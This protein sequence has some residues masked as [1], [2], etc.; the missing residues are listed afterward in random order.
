MK[1]MGKSIA[2]SLFDMEFQHHP[3]VKIKL[4]SVN[5]VAAHEDWVIEKL[6]RLYSRARVPLD[7]KELD[8]IVSLHAS[9][10]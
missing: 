5:G 7:Q 1:N 8:G 6:K 2:L 9:K 4:D 3:D 10:Y